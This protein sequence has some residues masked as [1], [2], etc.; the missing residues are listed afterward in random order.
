[1]KKMKKK[2][3]DAG[4]TFVETLAVLAVG[5]M[6]SA[7][8]S[9][10]AIHVMDTA[11]KTSAAQSIEQYKAALHSYYLDCGTFPS[12][13]QGLIALWEKPVLAPVPSSWKGPYV[14]RQIKD[15]PWGN[16]FVYVRNDSALFPKECPQ[17]LPYAIV[18]YGA[19][20]CEGGEKSNEDITSWK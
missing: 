5:A 12:S 6:L 10:S 8:A 13:Q 11:K 18:S 15:D 9:V 2:R 7:G 19:D 14:D 16:K 3:A 17:S 1:M 20:G 4:F